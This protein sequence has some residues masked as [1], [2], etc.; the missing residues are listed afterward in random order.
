MSI[1]SIYL[2]QLVSHIVTRTKY[3]YILY[4]KQFICKV[5]L[6]CLQQSL[7]NSIYNTNN[8]NENTNNNNKNN[9]NENNSKYNK[10]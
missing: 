1:P 5:A 4:V 8:N 3:I 2:Q 9:S 7:E 6:N 10:L